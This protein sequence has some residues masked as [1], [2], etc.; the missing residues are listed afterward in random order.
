MFKNQP[1]FIKF[2]GYNIKHFFKN[3]ISFFEP[4]YF[5]YESGIQ[6]PF[7]L[8]SYSLFKLRGIQ[9]TMRKNNSDFT[10]STL[11]NKL[12]DSTHLQEKMAFI[13]SSTIENILSWV[14]YE[15]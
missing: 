15:N 1:L 11:R 14:A 10:Q 7:L 5:W 8:F 6:K 13:P 9:P 2:E 3:Q 4:F 12:A